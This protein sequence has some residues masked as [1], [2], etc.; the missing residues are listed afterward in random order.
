MFW[1]FWF[2]LSV[3]FVVRLVMGGHDG[4]VCRHQDNSYWEP[5]IW[6]E[7]VLTVWIS[8]VDATVENGCMQMVKKGHT[9]GKT[10]THTIGSTTSTWY[11]TVFMDAPHPLVAFQ[12]GWFDILNGFESVATSWPKGGR[13]R[14]TVP[15]PPFLN[16]HKLC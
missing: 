6:D 1:H 10:A 15:L 9:C 3:H 14:C 12:G 16:R 13:W 11:C 8:L 2:L 7:E 5:R 4:A